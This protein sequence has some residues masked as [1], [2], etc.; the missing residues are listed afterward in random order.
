MLPFSLQQLRIMSAIAKK[1]SIHKAAYYLYL[2]Y[3]YVNKE[4][5][6]LEK[7]LNIKLVVRNS[8][9]TVLTREGQI[10]LKDVNKILLMCQE[11][12][13]KLINLDAETKNVIKIGTTPIT[14]LYIGS[15]VTT[16]FSIKYP[17]MK[18]KTQLDSTKSIL[19]QIITREIDMGIINEKIPVNN[20]KDFKISV[21]SKTNINLITS[22][23]NIN[24]TK[25]Q[26]SKENLINL[27]FVTLNQSSSSSKFLNFLLKKNGI[28]L[29][30]PNIIMQLNSV[31]AIKKV[32]S[33]NNLIYAF[34][35]AIS[36]NNDLNFKSIKIVNM[37]EVNNIFS[38]VTHSFYPKSRIFTRL[39]NELLNF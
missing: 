10:F 3:P 11:T 18:I 38:L 14:D 30:K 35:P 2:S 1:K 5:K 37:G 20:K 17:N 22:V 6:K 27:K 9:D 31:E 23:N 8:N 39:Y 21:F 15:I 36:V 16:Q 24:S 7:E 32:I 28:I 29:N 19:K 34:V 33:S 13:R 4:V 12:H 25:N 26:I